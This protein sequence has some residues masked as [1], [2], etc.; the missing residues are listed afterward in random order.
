MTTVKR[1]G[2]KKT[3]SKKDTAKPRERAVS[4]K[5]ALSVIEKIKADKS[6]VM[7]E[8]R[9]LGCYHATLRKA[10]RA[11]IGESAYAKL[12]S[13]KKAAKKA[14]V[15]KAAKKPAKKAPKSRELPPVK[16]SASPGGSP[17]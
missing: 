12:M 5:E 1:G 13:G 17:A 10:L 15:K 3:A 2:A 9:R 7:A 14:P 6:T 16:D 8:A 4:E 11:A